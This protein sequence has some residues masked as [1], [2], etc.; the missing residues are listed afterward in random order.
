MLKK[1]RVFHHRLKEYTQRDQIRSDLETLLDNAAHQE[2]LE[3]KLNWLV[4]LMRW[5]RYEWAA[6]AHLEDETGRLPLTRLKFLF[7]MLERRPEAKKHVARILRTVVQ[8]VSGMEFYTETGLPQEL[9][10]WSELFER[11]TQK[12][13]PTPPLDSELG[14]LFMAL[15]PNPEDALWVSNMDSKTFAQIV[16]LFFHEVGEDEKDWNRLASD[17]EDALTYLVIQIRAIGLSPEMRVRVGKESFRD[18]AFFAMVR[19]LE[20]FTTAFH[21]GEPGALQDKANRFRSII[22]ECRDELNLVHRHLDEFGV[23]LSLVFQMIRISSYLQR[24]EHLLDL[25]LSGKL[26]GEIET[27]KVT[28]FLARLIL[29]NQELR[30]VSSLFSQNISLMARK[31]V[32]RAAETGEHYITRTREQ[33]SRML[34]AGL[35]GGGVMSFAVYIKMGIVAIGLAGFVEGFLISI[36]YALGFV[37][38]HLLGFT[39]GTK[40]AAM[41][42]PAIADKMGNVDSP[43]G[44]DSLV[45]EVTHLVRSQMVSVLGNVLM[46]AP[47]VILIDS[48]YYLMTGTHIMSGTTAQYQMHGSSLLSMAPVYAALTG[49]LLWISSMASGWAGNWFALHSL[50]TTLARSPSLNFIFGKK[51]AKIIARFLDRNVAGLAANISLGFLLG[52]VPEFMRFF[53]IPL[54]IR[55]VTISAGNVGGALTVLGPAYVKTLDFW[56]AVLGVATIGMLNVGVSF[57]LSVWVAIRARGINTPQKKAIRQA[58]FRRFRREPLSF[59]W[60]R[61]DKK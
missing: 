51:R 23:S 40:Q 4:E 57:A 10:L 16:G 1:L 2:E 42:G 36:N 30:S 22:W 13:L 27:G 58:V 55:H 26:E 34:E 46:I 28:S 59:F 41:T 33:F 45:T 35:G 32:E 60:P 38:V 29:E 48:L 24:V 18:S 25:I 50:K 15:F 12:I 11:I 54:D 61:S 43:E 31:L 8:K 52:M 53:G 3:D 39:I 49:V 44:M 21:V 47:T 56:M 20:E 5:V 14:H 37:L 19:G 9:G 17:L 6:D 7:K